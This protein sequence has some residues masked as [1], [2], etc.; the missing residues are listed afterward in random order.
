M[1][2]EII[3]A[4]P[5]QI[6]NTVIIKNNGFFLNRIALMRIAVTTNKACIIIY[7]NT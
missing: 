4:C 6:Q 1:G 3:N 5:I 2:N 7:D